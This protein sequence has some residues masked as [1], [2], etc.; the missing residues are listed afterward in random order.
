MDCRLLGKEYPKFAQPLKIIE[1]ALYHQTDYP[2]PDL[3]DPEGVISHL[4]FDPPNFA[5]EG[6]IEFNELTKRFTFSPNQIL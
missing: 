6:F 1:M 4:S 5:Q 2:L 3:V